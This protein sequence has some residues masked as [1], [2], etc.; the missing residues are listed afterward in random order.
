MATAMSS[1][2][3]AVST[4]DLRVPGIKAAKILQYGSLA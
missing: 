1:S 2:V 3:Q 4:A